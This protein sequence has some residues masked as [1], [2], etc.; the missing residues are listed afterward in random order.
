MAKIRRVRKVETGGSPYFDEQLWPVQIA[1]VVLGGFLMGVSLAYQPLTGVPWYRTAWPSLIGIPLVVIAAM[2]ALVYVDNRLFRRSLALSLVLCAIVHVAMVVQMLEL[3]LFAGA[4]PQNRPAS[5][6]VERRPP[7]LMPEYHPTQLIP[8]EDRP[9]QDFEKPVEAETP[10]PTPEPERIVRQPTEPERSPEQPQPVPLPEQQPT[11]E[12]NVVTRQVPNQSMPRLASQSSRLSRQVQ[13]SQARV[14]QPVDLPEATRPEAKAAEAKAVATP[15]NREQADAAKLAR[16]EL[17]ATKAAPNSDPQ[18]A[19]RD[20]E[21][22]PATTAPAHKSIERAK[23]DSPRV[24]Q[25]QIAAASPPPVEAA[26]SPNAE[27]AQLAV[28]RGEA[29]SAGNR[30]SPNLDASVAGGPSPAVVASSAARRSEATQRNPT[31]DALSPSMPARIARSRAEADIPTATVKA[32]DAPGPTTAGARRVAELTASSGAALARSDAAAR[33]DAVTAAKGTG[34]IDFGPTQIVAEAAGG[35]PSGG[36]QPEVNT[37]LATRSPLRRAATSGTPSAAVDARADDDGTSI[38]PTRES[39]NPVEVAPAATATSRSLATSSSSSARSARGTADDAPSASDSISA[40]TATRIER[41]SAGERTASSNQI[42]TRAVDAPVGALPERRMAEAAVGGTTSVADIPEVG[43]RSA[44]AQA[45]ADHQSPGLARAPLAR[46][47][48][49]ALAVDIAAPV[50]PGGL[51]TDFT[52]EVGINSRQ[53]REDSVNVELRSAR[54]MRSQVG[55]LPAVSTAAVIPTEAYSSRAAR[56]RGEQRTGGSG[57]TSPETEEAIERGLAFLARYQGASGGW[58]LQGF[59]EGASLVSDTAATALAVLAFQGAGYNH[60][61]FQYKDVV[62]GGIAYLLKGQ[63]ENGDLFMPLDDA[64][65]RSVWLYSHSLAAIAICEAY[66]M[67]QDQAL[68]QPAQKAI[69]FVVESQNMQRGGWRYAPGVGADT[70]V[71]GWMMMALKS[72]ELAGLDV[73]PAAY[74]RIGRWLDDAQKSPSEPHLYRYNPDAPNT[75]EQ[76]HGRAASKTMTAVG[77]LMRLY[78]GWHRDNP[79]MQRGAAYLA[80]NLPDLGTTREPLRDTYY[81]YYSTQV[82]A[83]VGGP[84][85]QAWMGRLHPL[86]VNSQTRQGPYG[87]SWD[88]QA[89][90]ADRWGPHAGRIYVTALNLLSLEVQYRKLPLYEDVLR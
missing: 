17:D 83:H 49:E 25:P 32:D 72:G 10:V 76:R 64:S 87:G 45:E 3:Q 73:P 57:S 35:R 63:K 1:L 70:S 67:T 33:H 66:G 12:P 60:R 38:T 6:R 71:T 27:P 74:R 36:G 59:P 22:T 56:V 90:I 79:N 62:R 11:P 31:G 20:N 16:A 48:S 81:W 85:W 13:P 58:S 78:T 50:G 19:R 5:K 61:E 68:R 53:G 47:R 8:E 41:S 55:G 37:Q 82:M 24:E 54:F 39:P 77:L 46:I 2:I 29:G 80:Q 84:S 43:P 42:A 89:P 21:R 26:A 40:A 9:R 34:D 15:V 44:V 51:G 18:V 75:P 28:T 52:P 86:L 69:D 30:R 23:S 88:P 65:N 14:S 7:K 4:A